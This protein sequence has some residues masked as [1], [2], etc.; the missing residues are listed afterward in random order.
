VVKVT[1][2][3]GAPEVAGTHAFSVHI[4]VNVEVTYIVLGPTEVMVERLAEVD[5][6]VTPP[7]V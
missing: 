2:V 6:L 4:F 3:I 1:V 7:A 5:L